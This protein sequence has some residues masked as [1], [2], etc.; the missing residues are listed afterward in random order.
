MEVGKYIK[1]AFQ[2]KIK[3]MDDRKLAEFNYKIINN[4]L[5]NKAYLSKWIS[6][7]NAKCSFCNQKEDIIHLLYDYSFNDHIW[8][9][10]GNCLQLNFT[11]KHV[12]LGYSSK[13][14]NINVNS[15]NYCITLI[16]Y[17]IYKY[18]LKVLNTN[19]VKNKRNFYNFPSFELNNRVK[20]LQNT[21]DLTLHCYKKLTLIL[22]ELNLY[23]STK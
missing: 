12:V 15:I 13:M 4:I 9:I 1:I 17:L 6:E 10:V 20:I 21:S 2:N 19:K 11:Y 5:I 8:H 7:T 18:W 16:S 14:K 3:Y 23:Y 22:H